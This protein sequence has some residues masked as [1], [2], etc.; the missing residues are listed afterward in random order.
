MTNPNPETGRFSLWNVILISCA[1]MTASAATGWTVGRTLLSDEIEQYRTAKS[2]RAPEAIE[3]MRELAETLNITLEE[4]KQ[5]TKTKEELNHLS[6]ENETLKKQVADKTARADA[7]E[8]ELR[9]IQGDKLVI[10]EGDTQFLVPREVALGVTNQNKYT[11]ECEVV[12]G[13]KKLTMVPGMSV[14]TK[15]SGGAIKVTLLT[16]PRD[17]CTFSVIK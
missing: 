2:W 14:E 5:F 1:V 17:Q 11:H 16:A 13:G 6:T 9:S 12:I 8:K 4:R 3:Q 7:L 15:Y 10:D